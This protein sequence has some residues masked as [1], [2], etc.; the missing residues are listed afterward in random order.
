MDNMSSYTGGIRR[1]H[2]V[3]ELYLLFQEYKSVC[4]IV[5]ISSHPAPSPP[6]EC[7]PPPEPKG[8]G[9]HSLA[10]EGAGGSQFGRLLKKPGTL[11]TL[12][13]TVSTYMNAYVY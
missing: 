2:C 3:E 5:R 6:S 4:P 10:G 8:C 7:V 9:Q 13:Y 11:S 1:I 12:W